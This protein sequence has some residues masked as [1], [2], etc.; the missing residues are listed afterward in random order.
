MANYKGARW[1]RHRA[2]VLRRD[3]YK[4]RECARFGRVTPAD[5][6]HHV[7]PAEE[8]PELFWMAWNC[9]SLCSACHNKMH[10][11]GTRTLTDLGKD[12]INKLENKHREQI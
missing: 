7:N 4:C 3:K 12:W 10:V 9:V 6:V 2:F 1:E 5:T 8:Y 11:R